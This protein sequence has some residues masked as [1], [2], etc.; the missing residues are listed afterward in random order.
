MRVFP[1][2]VPVANDDHETGVCGGFVGWSGGARTGALLSGVETRIGAFVLMSG[3]AAPVSAYA[4]QAPAG[5]RP[6]VRRV[7]GPVDPLRL[8]KQLLLLRD[9][10]LAWKTLQLLLRKKPDS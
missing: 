1:G 3:G 4:S 5:L 2:S 8:I 9:K 6:D 7:L 10:K